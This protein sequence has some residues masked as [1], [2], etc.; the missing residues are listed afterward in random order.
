[1]HLRLAPSLWDTRWR[2]TVDEASG[3]NDPLSPAS[4][5]EAGKIYPSLLVSKNL[6]RRE[7][8]PKYK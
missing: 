8:G 1:M 5:E 4:R 2:W 3:P 7:I 6:E